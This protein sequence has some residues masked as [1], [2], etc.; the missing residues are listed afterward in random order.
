MQISIYF[1]SLLYFLLYFSNA[2]TQTAVKNDLTTKNS[3]KTHDVKSTATN[4]FIKLDQ[5][6]AQLPDQ[7]LDYTTKSWACVFDSKSGLTWEV[8]SRHGT[9]NKNSHTY[10]WFNS[11]PNTNGGFMGLSN[12]GQCS[13]SPC[14]T[15]AFVQKLSNTKY[16]GLGNWRLPTREE[17]RNLVDYTINFPGPTVNSQYFPN[18]VAQFYWSA[19]PD[20]SNSDSA[21]G[22][23][24]TFGYDYSYF[25][26]DSDHLR[27]VHDERDDSRK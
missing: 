21:W 27:L 12:N 23:G 19:N 2:Y 8:K 7:T 22:I 14:N 11:N 15:Q 13:T 10:S 18:T 24:F 4:R 1:I 5:H 3:T 17:L 26:A 16:C 6:G 9:I 25:K 20:A